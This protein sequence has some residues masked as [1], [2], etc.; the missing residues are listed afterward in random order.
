VTI[1]SL[2]GVPGAITGNIA[3]CANTNENYSIAPVSGATSYIWTVPAGAVIQSGQ[4]TTAISVLWGSTSG[5]V[6]VAATNNCGNSAPGQLAV[7]LSPTPSTP[8][9]ITGPTLVCSGTTV[10]FSVPLVAGVTN[11]WTVPSD[12]T[13]TA[14]QGTNT[15]TVLWGIQAGFVSVTAHIGACTSSSTSL[16]VNVETIPYPAQAISGPDTV[17][18]GLSGYQYSIPLITNASTY[19]WTL[20]A[21]AVIDQGQGTNAISVTFTGSAVSGNIKVAGNNLCGTGVESSAFVFVTICTG[22]SRNDFHSRI[23]IYPNP[24][25]GILTVA[26]HGSEKQLLLNIT[27]L[28]GYSLYNETLTDITTD[29]VKKIDVSKFAKGVYMI[30]LSNDSGVVTE[31]FVVD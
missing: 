30:K 25:H 11:N 17:C 23:E 21:G 6:T 13:I 9:S 4:S 16:G 20:P 5:N 3:P 2:P 29:Y 28:R 15:I 14:G 19:T 31:K 26:I 24:V 18:Q 7:T 1:G 10:N 22:I 8:G 12:A 27:D